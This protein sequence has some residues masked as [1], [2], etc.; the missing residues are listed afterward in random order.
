MRATLPPLTYHG[1]DVDE[2]TGELCI[3]LDGPRGETMIV[4]L[5]AEELAARAAAYD[6]N[7]RDNRVLTRFV[8]NN[9]LVV[10]KDHPVHKRPCT[11]FMGEENAWLHKELCISGLALSGNAGIRGLELLC[12]E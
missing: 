5:S 2:R 11:S 1:A 12:N 8:A 10:Y 3:Y 7:G 6:R 4:V 9:N